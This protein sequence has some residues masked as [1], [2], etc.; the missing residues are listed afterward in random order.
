MVVKPVLD[1]VAKLGPARLAAM[2]AVTLALIGFFAF[3]IL[4][5]SRPE[6]GVLYT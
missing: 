2:G 3:V 5:V 4:R 6:M 1:L